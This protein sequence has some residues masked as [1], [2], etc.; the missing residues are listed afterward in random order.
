MRY[1]YI[2]FDFDGTLAD[3]E[4]MAVDIYQE[5]SEKYGLKPIRHNDVPTLKNL[6][7][8]QLMEYIQ[9]RK[10]QVPFVL[11]HA[12]KL[13]HHQITEV[14]PCR[15]NMMQVLIRLKAERNIKI[16]II[17]TN[18][19]K[20]VEAFL[21]QNNMDFFDVIISSSL[22]GKAAKL[23]KVLR[24]QDLDRAEIAYVGDEIRDI[25]AAKKL[26]IDIIS[27]TWGYNSPES[28]KRQNP[29]HMIDDM[30]DLLKIC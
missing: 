10:L 22:F 11:L 4:T 20:N 23:K 15:E 19:K 8:A 6:S 24:K 5:I 25:D 26:D 17:T 13:L 9:I 3:T 7:M 21:R 16:G 30:A 12:K 18:S 1:K 27:V 28:L 2:L 29:D 14:K